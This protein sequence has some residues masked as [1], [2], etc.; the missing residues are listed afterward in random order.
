MG[1]AG[2]APVKEIHFSITYRQAY[3]FAWS[4]RSPLNQL[5]LLFWF[6]H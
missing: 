5:E 4:L 2:F 6:P 1:E 3:V